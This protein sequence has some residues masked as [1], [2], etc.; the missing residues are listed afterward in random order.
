MPSKHL[1]SILDDAPEDEDLPGDWEGGAVRHT[2]GNIFNREYLN[3]EKQL[4]VVYDPRMFQH[5]VSLERFE[6]AES[7]DY[8]DHRE[9]AGTIQHTVPE[10]EG[11]TDPSETVMVREDRELH[12]IALGMMAGVE[13]GL[14]E[15]DE[16]DEE[17]WPENVEAM[18]DI[19]LD[20]AGHPDDV[21]VLEVNK[22]I[23]VSAYLHKDD[24]DELRERAGDIEGRWQFVETCEFENYDDPLTVMRLEGGE[25][26]A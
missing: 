2:G 8:P 7:E 16:E 22:G 4:K 6:W 1:G 26:D 24:H 13:H 20:L 12:Q 9:F 3:D 21:Q 5:G 15:D 17:G 10:G 25:R 11:S 23:S 14:L 19:F 18:R